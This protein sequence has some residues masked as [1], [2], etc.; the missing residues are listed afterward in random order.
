MISGARRSTQVPLFI[1]AACS[2]LLLTPYLLTDSLVFADVPQTIHYQGKLTES[3]GGPLV[4]VHTVTLRLYDAPTGGTKLWEEQ[5]TLT[6]SRDDDGILSIE[7]GSRTPFAG[8]VSFNDPVFLAIEVDASREF[9]PRQ[10][11][12]SVGYAINADK[13][14]GFELGTKANDIVQLDSSGAL[15][16]VSGANLTHLNAS[17]LAGGA[18][19][20][21]RLSANV[22]LFGSS[23]DSAEL[24]ENSVGA[25]ALASG[26]IQAGDIEEGDLPAHA[27][28]HQPGGSDALP[29][30]AAVS[31][32]SADTE[33]SSTSLARA[34][35]A[36]QGLH[37][38]AASGQ[39]QLTGDATLAAGAHITLFQSG[40]TITVAGTA[41]EM[42]RVTN[43]AS[44]AVAIATASDTDL[45][46]VTITKSS[47]GSA[48]LI[49]ATVQL[50]H[51]AN[52]PS[53]SVDVKLFRD[54]T[55]LDAAYTGRIGTA[56]GTA[57]RLPATLHFV[58]SPAAGTFTLTLRARSSGNGAEATV[59]R[60]TVLELP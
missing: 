40:Q 46:S 19:P 3:G 2:F 1:F 43:A 13:L 38:I 41:G 34:D 15:P 18:V 58:D 60:L 56:A 57:Q 31:V 27:G 22:S 54:A 6:F 47:A 14:D 50:N 5:H 51:A 17:E 12:T 55:Q 42:N 39:P 8:L 33:G 49:L 53:K 48:L 36:H 35:H 4:G 10:T 21:A 29:T 28:I 26:A 9:S 45:L 44:G 23:V 7:L 59:R 52:P 25:A 20:D 24:A 32:G 30:A 16:A 11:L 37:S